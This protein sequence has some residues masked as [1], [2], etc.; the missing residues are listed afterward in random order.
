ML[1]KYEHDS[2]RMVQGNEMGAIE[3]VE[4]LNKCYDY[5]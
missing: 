1:T 2:A 5:K 3:N 4:N